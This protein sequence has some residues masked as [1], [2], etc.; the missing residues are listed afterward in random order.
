MKD[1][2]EG[3]KPGDDSMTVNHDVLVRRTRSVC[4]KCVR[5]CPAEVRER[6]GEVLLIKTCAEHGQTQCRLSGHPWYYVGLDRYYFSVMKSVSRQRDYLLRMTER[7]NLKCPICLAS[8]LDNQPQ[9]A[10]TADVPD[11]NR[12]RMQE[13]LRWRRGRGPLKIDLLSAEPTLREDLFDIVREMKSLGHIV[14][15]HTNG[16]RLASDEYVRR[17]RE[18]GVDEVHLQMDGFDDAAYEKIR[19]ARLT[20]SKRRAM[21]NMERHDLATDIVM[22]IM[23]DTNEGQ[24]RP[25]LQDCLHR[26]FVRELFFL[27]TR[28]LGYF[29]DSDRVL[30]PDDVIDIVERE[31]DG[32]CQRADVFRFQKLYFAL[33]AVL[34]VRK[35]LYVQHYLLFRDGDAWLPV[36]QI[37]DWKR[38]DEV[39]DEL[40]A[41]QADAANTGIIAR[42]SYQARKMAW[43]FRLARAMFSW[44]AVQYTPDFL[45]LLTHL[46]GGWL[47]SGLPRRIL[48]LGY[49]TACDPHNFDEEVA[50]H[51]GKGEVSMDCGFNDSSAHANI[52]RERRWRTSPRERPGERG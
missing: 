50:R 24:I 30:M 33:L 49:I 3:K 13:F 27:G 16:V 6:D 23:P 34:G 15:L 10:A 46:R 47:L 48:L 8:A 52:M 12:E 14:A 7:C 20:A 1:Y 25:V 44:R 32:L 37:L 29:A 36:S 43:L 35:C 38:I 45:S 18:A 42:L 40:P 11:L 26:P 39:L 22:V 21:D 51:C 4:S 41:L 19:G 17:L 5:R 31:S 9:S 2:S 28:P